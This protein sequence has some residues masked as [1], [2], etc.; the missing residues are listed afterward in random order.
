[1]APSGT[2]PEVR[3]GKLLN[4]VEEFASS[5]GLTQVEA[6]VNLSRNEAYRSMLSHGFRIERTGIAMHRPLEAGY[7]RPGVFVIDDWR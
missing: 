5:R 4:A 1:M 7:S 6:G 3:F 2:D